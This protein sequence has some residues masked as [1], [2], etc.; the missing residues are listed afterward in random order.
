MRAAKAFA[1]TMKTGTN[2]DAIRAL[3]TTFR[4]NTK[5]PEEEILSVMKEL[6]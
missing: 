6:K 1:E 5:I 3:L 2:R 4:D